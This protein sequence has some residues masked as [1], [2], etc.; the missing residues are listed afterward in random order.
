[1]RIQRRRTAKD[2]RTR[3]REVGRRKPSAVSRR[4]AVQGCT[5]IPVEKRRDGG[6]RFWCLR[7][8]EDA[9][10]KYGRAAKACRG[11]SDVPLLASETFTLNIDKFQ[12]GVGLWGAVP[13]VYDTTE[14]PID[15][16]I[17]VHA[18]SAGGGR[19]EID[20]TFRRIKLVGG[21]IPHGGIV[22]SELDA[23]YYMVSSVFRLPMKEVMCKSCGL[24]H[25]DKD[26]FSLH[27]HGRHLC[28]GCG[29]HFRDDS[30]AIGNPICGARAQLGAAP[31]WTKP[32]QRVLRIR[33][34]EFP[35]GIQVWGSNP[36]LLWTGHGPEEEGIH[37][38][39]Y[40]AGSAEPDLDDTYGEV[41]ID[42]KALN[43][44]HVRT[45]MAQNTLPHLRGRVSAA[46]CPECGHSALGR[47]ASLFT[48]SLIHTCTACGNTFAARCG[49]LAKTV[50]NPL[51]ARL[52]YLSALAP[53]PPRIHDLGLRTEVP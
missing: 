13:P 7:H 33:Q 43:P 44:I 48:P 50:L 46:A 26:W 23:I 12:G 47:G 3:V 21:Q 19:K 14:L 6:I 51:P 22:L 5:I 31:P 40:A 37:V 29:K 39:A 11:A 42:G 18:R 1:M 20:Q 41:R 24:S 17:H 52:A 30:R 53:R 10:A 16:G 34:Q 8:R 49:R 4:D 2:R 28:A 9:T 15:R 25:L 36:A 38:H 35:G 45:L 32:S 27:P